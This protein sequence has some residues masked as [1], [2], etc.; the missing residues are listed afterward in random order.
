MY[1]SSAGTLAVTWASYSNDF[2][3]DVLYTRKLAV[4]QLAQANLLDH[5]CDVSGMLVDSALDQQINVADL[6]TRATELRTKITD[7]WD[8]EAIAITLIHPI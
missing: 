8:S 6:R 4:V 7:K 2:N 1:A 3:T 5:L